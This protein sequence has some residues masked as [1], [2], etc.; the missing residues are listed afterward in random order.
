MKKHPTMSK[1]TISFQM[2]QFPSSEGLGVGSEFK[3]VMKHPTM[4][5]ETISFQMTQF[6]SSERL[7]VGFEFKK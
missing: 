1:E 7:G 4:S 6:P 2:T 5:K 3:K